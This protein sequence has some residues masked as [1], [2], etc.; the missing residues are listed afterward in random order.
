MFLLCNGG[1]DGLGSLSVLK[2]WAYHNAVPDNKVGGV[3]GRFELV[4][5]C[6]KVDAM[7]G[8]KDWEEP[9]DYLR[10]A[11]LF[12]NKVV[13]RAAGNGREEKQKGC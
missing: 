4:E 10:S 1:G 12:P 9:A 13:L 2:T 7:V 3:P 8:R 11:R 5:V 6:P